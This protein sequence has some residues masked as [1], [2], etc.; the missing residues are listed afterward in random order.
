MSYL[1]ASHR[2]HD[3]L[4]DASNRLRSLIEKEP[5]KGD[6]ARHLEAMQAQ[7][8]A[9]SSRTL[10]I[11]NE[12]DAFANTDRDGKKRR[13]VD[14]LFRKYHRHTRWKYAIIIVVWVTLL[15]LLYATTTY[16]SDYAAR[17]TGAL[18]Q[19][20]TTRNCVRAGDGS[21]TEAHINTALSPSIGTIQ[22]VTL[23]LFVVGMFNLHRIRQDIRLTELVRRGEVYPESI[24]P[25]AR[26]LLFPQRKLTLL[27]STKAAES[28]DMEWRSKSTTA[29]D[30][31]TLTDPFIAYRSQLTELYERL[32]N[33]R[34]A[35][36]ATM[37]RFIG[38]IGDIVK[39][40]RHY[41]SVAQVSDYLTT[42]EESFES[43][44]K[45]CFW[46][47]EY[48]IW[49]LPTVGFIGTIYG[50]SEALLEAKD[51][52]HPD[53]PKTGFAT[54]FREVIDS[55]GIAFDTTLFALLLV[56]ILLFYQKMTEARMAD[57][58]T[59]LVRAVR[60]NVVGRLRDAND[61]PDLRLLIET[62]GWVDEIDPLP[63]ARPNLMAHQ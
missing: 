45:D 37:V 3:A 5:L 31:K 40:A 17:M 7:W 9:A 54:E 24:V 2:V 47:A 25:R 22:K 55:L 16:T 36:G 34:S 26:G 28:T 15:L 59:D 1:T 48:F 27:P 53:R 10:E 50:I 4:V 38:V 14:K 29:A 43:S 44:L 42:K 46:V 51:M 20:C 8:Q 30:E 12:K 62:R 60:D 35:R 52:F 57:L 58:G 49:L 39:K 61:T 33:D 21:S 32:S 63:N 56:A 23:L 18:P 19:E 41:E 13:H 11:A 6:N